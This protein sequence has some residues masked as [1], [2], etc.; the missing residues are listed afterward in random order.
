MPSTGKTT[1][2][3]VP[4]SGDLSLDEM[5]AVLLDAATELGMSFSHITKLGTKRYPGNRHW[6]LKRSRDEPGCLDVTYWPAGP[7]LWVSI[8]QYEPGW[9]H[10]LGRRL[11][12][13]LASRLG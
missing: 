6:H 9:V 2:L 12:P 4:V 7:L 1:N 3:D 10:D 5:E 8:R 13:A 11:V